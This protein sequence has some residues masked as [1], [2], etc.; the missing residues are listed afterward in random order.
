M[1]TPRSN[2][3][4]IDDIAD[5]LAPFHVVGVKLDRRNHLFLVQV[6]RAGGERRTYSLDYEH[7]TDQVSQ[8]ENWLRLVRYDLARE[9]AP[10]SPP[11]L[12]ARRITEPPVAAVRIIEYW[13]SVLPSRIVNEDLSDLVERASSAF[14]AGRRGLGWLRLAAA[15]FW[16]SMNTVGYLRANLKGNRRGA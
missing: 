3:I 10:A 16:S 4:S 14:A 12:A 8:I 9:T 1:T 7:S 2:V 13:A 5:G 11:P 6:L 15:L